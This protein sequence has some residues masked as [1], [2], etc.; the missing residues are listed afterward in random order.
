[1]TDI[2][3]LLRTLITTPLVLLVILGLLLLLIGASGGITYGHWLT[4]DKESHRI[5]LM[6]VGCILIAS[7]A[8]PIALKIG[9][10]REEHGGTQTPVQTEQLS[11]DKK[12]ALPEIK[13]TY[14]PENFQVSEKIHVLGTITHMPPAQYHLWLIRIYPTGRFWPVQRIFVS[15]RQTRWEGRG[16]WV[17]GRSGQE[18]G[19]GAFLVGPGGQKMFDYLLEAAEH[20]NSWMDKAKIAPNTEGR[21][22]PPIPHDAM[23]ALD[24]VECDRV[25]KVKR[26]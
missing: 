14:P 15:E 20:H 16:Y 6:I 21:N 8:S 9:L 19:I 10:Q 11:E 13:I 25:E 7:G 3:E 24:V 22:L 5:L 23:W 18:R 26:S 1:M 12:A 17:G 2:P 4:I